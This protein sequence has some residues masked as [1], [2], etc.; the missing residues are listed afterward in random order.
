MVAL[1]WRYAPSALIVSSEAANTCSH[2]AACGSTAV[3]RLLV[4]QQLHMYSLY[5]LPR[6]KGRHYRYKI[7]HGRTCTKVAVAAAAVSYD[8]IKVQRNHQ[9]PGVMPIKKKSGQNAIQERATA[10]KQFV[11]D[12][13]GRANKPPARPKESGASPAMLRSGRTRTRV[14]MTSLATPSG[15]TSMLRSIKR[16]VYYYHRIVRP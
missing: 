14:R 11:S 9:Q 3:Y 4:M 2:L 1:R 10:E 8:S 12:L 5:I 7:K 13:A 6:A 15:R 16:F